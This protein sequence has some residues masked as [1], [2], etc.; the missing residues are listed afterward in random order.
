MRLPSPPP[1]LSLPE[2]IAMMAMI[3][4]TL[5]FSIDAMLPALP[6]IAAELTPEAPNRAM[7]IIAA[8]VLGM[9]V[10]TLFAGPLSDSFGRKRV[11]LLGAGL[12]CVASVVAWAAPTLELVL[13]ARLVQ[14]LGVAAPRVVALAIIRDLHK[15]RDMARITSFV[16]MVFGLVPAIAP[17]LGQLIIW[18]A[19]WRAIFAAFVLFMGLSMTWMGLRLRE[20]LPVSAR[21]PFS[22]AALGAG[23]SEVLGNRLVQVSVLV[24]SLCFCMLVT[25]LQI[26]QPVMDETYGR[27]AQFAWWFMLIA[28]LAASASVINASLVRRLGMRFMVRMMLSAQL[29]L[30]GG[31]AAAWSLAGLEGDAGFAVFI[32]WNVGIFFQAGM[33]LGNMNAIAME[34]MGHRA[35][36]TAAVM[37]AASTVLAVLISIPI[38][39]AFDGHPTP[40]AL[41]ILA[42]AA[43]ALALMRLLP[44]G[45]ATPA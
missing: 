15:G 1:T 16:F 27:G 17:A 4:A 18:S 14:G 7:L 41:A 9:G 3:F 26:T 22:M 30:S 39:Q 2:F 36:L 37:G 10:G 38:G 29:V 13:A 20:T 44:E 33:T 35:G 42:C 21:Q 19:G 34:P 23:L 40:I 45:E 5:A 12:Y 24:Q 28:A 32:A 6:E 31:A 25:T 11:I 43:G 8:F